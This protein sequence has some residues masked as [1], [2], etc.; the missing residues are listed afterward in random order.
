[1]IRF[2]LEMSSLEADEFCDEILS[3]RL[4]AQVVVTGADFHFGHAR[5]G[6]PETLA[7]AGARALGFET[8]AVPLI[9]HAGERISSTRIRG[10]IGSGD[11]QGAALLLGARRRWRAP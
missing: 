3:K 5:S 2:D 10:L 7:L 11:V 6:T 4:G 8:I 1:M 9:E